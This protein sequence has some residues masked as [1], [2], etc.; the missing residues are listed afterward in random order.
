M[1]QVRIKTKAELISFFASTNSDLN[2]TINREYLAMASKKIT[3]TGY[4]EEEDV[5]TC[6]EYS[7]FAIP[8]IFIGSRIKTEF[9][10]SDFENGGTFVE[11]AKVFGVTSEAVRA[12]SKKALLKL[13]NI[14]RENNQ[15]KEFFDA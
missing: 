14:I 2:D 12:T 7:E 3:L 10:E 13:E 11:I 9:T 15:L 5:F 1:T 6:Q 4:C 8:S